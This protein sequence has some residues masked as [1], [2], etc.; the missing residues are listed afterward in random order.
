MELAQQR[1]DLSTYLTLYTP[2][3]DFILQAVAAGA[4]EMLL[5]DILDRCKKQGNRYTYCSSVLCYFY[6]AV[7][8]NLII[9]SSALLLN[10]IMAAF[11][12]SYIASRALQFIDLITQCNDEGMV[13]LQLFQN[14]FS[15]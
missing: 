4:S 6:K 12:P 5:A 15:S 1:I 13:N 10:A 11:K 9:T 2:A 3:L 14:N 8:Y 7:L